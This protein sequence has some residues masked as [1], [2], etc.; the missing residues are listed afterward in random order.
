MGCSNVKI[1][2]E[3]KPDEKERS[4]SGP[5]QNERPGGGSPKLLQS[6]KV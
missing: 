3:G 1:G 4:K 2:I 6:N 5:S